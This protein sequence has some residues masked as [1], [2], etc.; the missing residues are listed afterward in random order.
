MRINVKQNLRDFDGKSMTEPTKDGVKVIT[1]DVICE[2]ALLANNPQKPISGTEKVTR[3]EL[4]RKI[5]LNEEVDFTAEEIVLVKKCVDEV[6]GAI[7]VGPV[8][9]IL[10]G[11]DD[12]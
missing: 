7:I 9:E 6:F 4:A 2:N 8:Y 11:K 10:E 3:Y 12:E 1:L 5:H